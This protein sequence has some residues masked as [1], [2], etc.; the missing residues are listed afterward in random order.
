[1]G[2]DLTQLTKLFR[3][4]GQ[5]LILAPNQ[6]KIF[7]LIA[8]NSHPRNQVIAPTQ[9]GKSLTVALAVLCRA[10]GK[11]EKFIVLA[12]S[13]KKAQIVMQYIIDHCFDSDLFMSQ[14]ELEETV[15]LDRL[16]RERSRNHITFKTG[17][18][19]MTLTLDARNSKRSFEAAMGFGGNRL[20]LDES[21]LIED[22]LYAT[23]KRMLGG[24][25][26]EDTFLLEI[27]NPF[28]RNHF[29]RTWNR[30]DYNKI[31]IDYQIGLKEGR[32]DEK[33]IEEMR[34][35]AFFSVYYECLFPEEDVIDE[36]G[37]RNLITNEQL[38]KSFIID[39]PL[40][41]GEELFL[42]ADIAGGEDYNVF[43]MRDS[44]HAW[45]EAQNRS[46]DTMTNVAE[47]QR[48]KAKYRNLESNHILIDDI[49]IG[50]GVT[51]RLK[52]LGLHTQGVVAG[53]E[54]EEKTKFMNTKAEGYWLCAR[55]IK[56]GGK[57]LRNDKFR[58]LA[59]IKYKVNTDKVLQI[60]PKDD[61][62]RRT[63][64]SPDFAE[65][66]MLTF[67]PPDP[68]PSIRFIDMRPTSGW[69]SW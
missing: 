17:G 41:L 20:I 49:G 63:G 27:G 7:N 26:Y 11:G 34:D 55:W 3:V 23:V 2:N 25:P 32:Y 60:E 15:S 1:M 43:V 12:P 16:R 44:K 5:E 47:I 9:Y 52:E 22:T 56:E 38:N 61:L 45:V 54:P 31:F 35:E 39:E 24:Y 19:V 29:Y 40:T 36:F 62:K 33:F 6:Q 66:L 57:L 67:V 13:E 10:V 68:E 48:I 42:G 50:R 59:W 14:L 37:Y 28:Y 69:H 4:N 8:Q 30:S 65:A 53:G 18:G 51:D 58:Q 46:N 64:K 21:S